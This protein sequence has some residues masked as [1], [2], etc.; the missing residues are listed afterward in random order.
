MWKVISKP[1]GKNNLSPEVIGKLFS[2]FQIRVDTKI[3]AA[4]VILILMK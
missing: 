2:V 4:Q 1:E 3:F